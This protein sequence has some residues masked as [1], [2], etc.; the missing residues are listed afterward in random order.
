MNGSHSSSEPSISANVVKPDAQQNKPR[1]LRLKSYSNPTYV[2]LKCYLELILLMKIILSE[3]TASLVG[4]LERGLGYHIEHRKNGFFS[5]RD[6]RGSV[7]PDGH[8][9]F[10]FLCAEMAQQGMHISDV[11]LTREELADALRE[12]RCTYALFELMRYSEDYPA[13][14]NAQQVMKFKERYNL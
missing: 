7:P 6:Q 5:K 12:A 11:A 1:R 14:F 2:L 13:V 4:T 9:R 3:M 8:L 10:I